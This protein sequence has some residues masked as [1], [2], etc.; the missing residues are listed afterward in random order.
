MLTQDY[1]PNP[2]HSSNVYLY[3]RPQGSGNRGIAC[4]A[5]AVVDDKGNSVENLSWP[6]PLACLRS[7]GSSK[8]KVDPASLEE[9][10]QFIQTSLYKRD[11]N[12]KRPGKLV[13]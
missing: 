8:I 3:N 1:S 2:V 6:R 13:F 9:L 10:Q 4:I 5:F 12:S 7:E 11:V